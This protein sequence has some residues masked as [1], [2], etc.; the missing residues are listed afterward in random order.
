MLV[1]SAYNQL[2]FSTVMASLCFGLYRFNLCKL[3]SVWKY[4]IPVLSF[5]VYNEMLQP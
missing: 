3:S 2:A 4:T 1:C 5:S